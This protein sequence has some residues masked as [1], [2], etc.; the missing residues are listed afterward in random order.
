MQRARVLRQVPRMATAFG[1]KVLVKRRRYAASGAVIR[2]EFDERWTDGVYLGLSDQVRDGHLVYVD[3]VFTHSRNVKDKAKLVDA[4]DHRDGLGEG[5]EELLGFEPESGSTPTARRRIVGK[6]APRVAALEGQC[7]VYDDDLIV[8]LGEISELEGEAEQQLPRAARLGATPCEGELEQRG[9]QDN[10]VNPENYAKEILYEEEEVDEGFELLPSQQFARESTGT[11]EGEACPKAWA[12]GAYRHGGVLG[13]R[14]SS[15]TFPYATR[16]VN[17]FIRAKLGEDATWS[18]FSIHRNFSVKR[19]R[20]SHNARDKYSRLIRITDFKEGGLWTQLGAN[21]EVNE[22]EI[23]MLDGKRGRIH[24]L[25]S[26]EGSGNVVS[27][28]SR[29]W[30]ATMPWKGERIVIA[31]Y[32]VRGLG[33]MSQDDEDLALDLNGFPLPQNVAVGDEPKIRKLLEGEGE[34]QTE[35]DLELETRESIMHVRMSEEE[36]ITTSQTHGLDHYIAAMATRWRTIQPV[37]GD[38]NSVIHAAIVADLE[39]DWGVR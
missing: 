22:D 7:D 2:L 1:A 14:N 13:I 26:E 12:S 32:T 5:P 39:S 11:S 23:V 34:N 10:G 20:D 4:G 9:D 27:F 16:V 17:Q 18:T 38:L 21:E 36:W 28:D 3:G 19:H 6:S 24:P 33:K 15:K 31:V 37:D 25:H 8:D 30:H 29:Q 35:M